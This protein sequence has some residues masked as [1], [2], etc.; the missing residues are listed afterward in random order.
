MSRNRKWVS[1]ES[2]REAFGD[3][4]ADDI[5]AKV[6]T[7]NGT[8]GA[9]AEDTVRVEPE[10]FQRMLELVESGMPAVGQ[11]LP[12]IIRLYYLEKPQAR[13]TF[14]KWLKTQTKLIE[15]ARATGQTRIGRMVIKSPSP[16]AHAPRR[17]KVSV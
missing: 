15:E 17:K 6:Q 10:T 2:L 12:G 4:L 14:K 11:L 16:K 9:A 3:K 8:A 1:I 7:K 13:G 5:V